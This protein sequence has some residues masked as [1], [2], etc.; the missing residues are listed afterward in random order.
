MN[1]GAKVRAEAAA[2][3]WPYPVPVRG[4]PLFAGGRPGL[5]LGG[6]GAR[7]LAS[8][9][10]L[11]VLEEEELRPAA[12]AGTSMG[13]LIGA[14]LAAGYSAVACHGIASA[15]SWRDVLDFGRGGGLIRGHRYAQWLGHHLPAR[16]SELA[17]PLV[18]T[19]TDIERGELVA[20]RDGDLIAALRASTAFPGAFAP[21]EIEGRLLLDG[22]ILNTLPVDLIR[23]YGVSPIV[24]ADFAAPRARPVRREREE[25]A[26]QRFWRPLTFRRRSM[27]ADILLK[28]VDIMQNEITA[29]RLAA[30]P[31]DILIEPVMDEI[32][33][34]DFRR[35]DEI[36]KAGADEANRVLAALR[37]R[38]PDPRLAGGNGPAPPPSAGA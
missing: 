32:N 2:A 5:V 30:A 12:I 33:L 20:L 10:V 8:I 11:E 29:T 34:E 38:D 7:G 24:A 22:G 9:G 31:P 17:V 19:A 14:F 6:G 36:I 21:V 15:L 4:R 37:R 25:S 23:E 1:D 35:Y 13:A 27:A 28:A 3:R 26:W 16:F 18:V